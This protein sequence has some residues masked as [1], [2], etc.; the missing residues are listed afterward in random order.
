MPGRVTWPASRDAAGWA[1][2]SPLVIGE[3]VAALFGP[4]DRCGP[5]GGGAATG[6]GYAPSRSRD[7][8]D[9]ARPPPCTTDCLALGADTGRLN[10]GDGAAR[11]SVIVTPCHSQLVLYSSLAVPVLAQYN[12]YHLR[13]N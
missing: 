6:L 1:A 7:A 3:H 13:G 11:G 9:S 5:G 10:A 4:E 12:W 8:G 2:R